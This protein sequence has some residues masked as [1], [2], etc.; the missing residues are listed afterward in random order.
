MRLKHPDMRPTGPTVRLRFDDREIEALEGETIAAALAA[1][2]V[3]AVRQA[4]S[5]APRG[6]FCGMGVCFD[7]LVT[8]DGR[9]SQR[10]CLTRVAAGMDVR[11]SPTVTA[12][13]VDPAPVVEEIACDVL[14][15]GAGPAGL[16]AA[17]SLAL[18]GADVVVLDERLYP[19]GQFFKP[20]APSHRAELSTLDRQF[21]DGAVLAEST[22][23][24]GARMVNEA[25]VWAAF[26]PHEVAAVVAGQSRLYRPRR[27][28]LATG[29]YEQSPTVPGWTLP[30]VMTVGAL[31]TLARSYRVAPGKRI[32]IAG[33]GPLCLQTAVELLDG[34]ANVVAVL[35][36]AQRPGLA[37]RRALANAAAADPF[38][39]IDGISLARRLGKKL[40][41]NRRVTQL[42]G[43]DRVRV[44]TAGDLTVEADIVALNYG[45]ASSSELAR[46]LGCAHRFVSRGSG[47]M[48]TLTDR[49]GRTSVCEVFAIGDGAR[50]GGAHAAMAQGTLAAAAIAGDLGLNAA[51][52]IK[53]SVRSVARRVSRQHSGSCSTHPLSIP[54]RSTTA[55]S[56][57][58]ARR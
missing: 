14:V 31:Q 11:S 52:P 32:V 19:G 38:L 18:A 55:Q 44:V 29:A 13:T 1:A 54:L 28:V 25:T 16:S 56:S 20:L 17:R 58:A 24:A 23:R 48:E 47:S 37:Q 26:S 40:H 30:G 46:S 4:R 7:C 35:E 8:V 27:L 51:K 49:H 57:V 41:W 50:F 15:V 3:V 22:L 45:F 33:N 39:L 34:G 43:A 10:A 42:V 5:G 21:R 6:P 36:A 2:D 12:A 53:R 9:P